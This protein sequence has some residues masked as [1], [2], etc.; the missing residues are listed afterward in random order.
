MGEDTLTRACRLSTSSSTSCALSDST[1]T[2]YT[3]KWSLLYVLAQLARFCQGAIQPGSSRVASGEPLTLLRVESMLTLMLF[4]SREQ[5][6]RNLLLKH[7]LVEVD[8]SHLITFDEELAAQLKER[9]AD[10]LPL[11]NNH[12]RFYFSFLSGKWHVKSLL[13]IPS[14]NRPSRCSQWKCVQTQTKPM[15]CP[16]SKSCSC[17]M[18]I[19]F[20]FETWMYVMDP[21]PPIPYPDPP[22]PFPLFL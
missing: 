8:L 14:S 18:R 22:F 21:T 17:P 10:F 3:G 19:L 6:R 12:W 9:P 20:Y 13:R 16:I 2:L 7:F 1:M 4:D 15:S 11:V 5:L